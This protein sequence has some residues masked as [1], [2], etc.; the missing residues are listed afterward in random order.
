LRTMPSNV[1]ATKSRNNETPIVIQILLSS[2]IKLS[3]M[4]SI[5]LDG[6]EPSVFC[7]LLNNWMRMLP[8]LNTMLSKLTKITMIGE[9][10][11]VAKKE[12]A[13]ANINGSLSFRRI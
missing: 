1:V 9:I 12:V 6:L 11:N 13:E 10:E 7:K 8:D 5:S 4:F 3:T 2:D